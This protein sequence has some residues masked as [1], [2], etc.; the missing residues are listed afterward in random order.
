M[1]FINDYNCLIFYC[2][3]KTF[4]NMLLLWY[5]NKYI[6]EIKP[7]MAILQEYNYN[8]KMYASLA[9]SFFWYISMAKHLKYEYPAISIFSYA[10]VFLII[11]KKDPL[12]TK[13]H[14]LRR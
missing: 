11:V 1:R 4:E 7:F 14:L 12:V 10:A 5:R 3:H 9:V 13:S 2:P 6:V 8:T